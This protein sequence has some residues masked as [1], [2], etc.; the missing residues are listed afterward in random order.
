[1][2]QQF[3]VEVNLMAAILQARQLQGD[4]VV[5]RRQMFDYMQP[6][7]PARVVNKQKFGAEFSNMLEDAAV[8]VG[9]R[10][11]F[12]THASGKRKKVRVEL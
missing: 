10:F 3:Q 12:E 5:S 11:V 7:S 4:K 6:I 9:A 8:K 1:M 2:N